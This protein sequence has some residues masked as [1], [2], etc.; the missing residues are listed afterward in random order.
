MNTKK[1]NVTQRLFI[2]ISVCSFMFFMFL[3]SHHP[4]KAYEIL[5]GPI[6]VTGGQDEE[7]T[8]ENGENEPSDLNNLEITYSNGKISTNLEGGNSEKTWNKIFKKYKGVIA[9]LSGI[10][11]LTFVVFFIIN[12]AKLGGSASNPVAR[13]DALMGLLWTGISAAASGSVLVLTALFWNALK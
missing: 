11:L 7:L 8:T 5:S 9:G 10:C 2:L 4:V 12:L 13:K 3:G 1:I 6:T